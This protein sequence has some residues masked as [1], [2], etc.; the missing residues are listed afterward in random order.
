MLLCPI[1]DDKESPVAQMVEALMKRFEGV[2]ERCRSGRP[3][4][5]GEVEREIQEA[6]NAVGLA[7]MEVVLQSFDPGVAEIE[8]EGERMRR[9][10]N[11]S[12]EYVTRFGMAR[13]GRGLYRGSGRKA[14]T[15]CPLEAGA[16]IIGGL[17]TPGAARLMA[18]M[19]A[20]LTL[21]DTQQLCQELGM[22]VSSSSLGRLLQLLSKAWEARRETHETALREAQMVP[23]EAAV[24]SASV[25]GVLAPMREKAASRQVKREAAGKHA[26]G[27]AGYSEVG[28][29]TASLHDGDGARLSTIY[30]ARMPEPK[31]ATLGEELK[32]EI[33]HLQLLQ[34]DLRRVYL[35]DGAAVNWQIAGSIEAAVRQQCEQEHTSYQKAVEI[36]D[37]FH[38]CEHLKR[39]CDASC[40]EGTPEGKTV[41]ENLRTKLKELDGG[42]DCVINALR[43]RHRKAKRG[44]DRIA[45]ELNYFRK[46]RARMHYARYQRENLPI[47]SGVVEA[48]C[49]TIVTQRMK[50][51]GMAWSPEG[52]QAILTLRTWLRSNRFDLAWQILSDCFKSAPDSLHTYAEPRL[53]MAA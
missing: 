4:D 21:R 38:A 53:K 25:D 36:V 31:K 23:P 22:Q 16:G 52:G 9:V 14:K 46:Q 13:V 29:G 30:Q 3:V 40:G 43:Y 41:F 8:F 11:S 12:A 51:S 44:R 35:A 18:L 50:R 28:C 7:C 20:E 17:W 10:L 49:K 37:Y 19:A 24:V 1:A 15:V 47:G 32:A 27:P 26:S 45:P 42:V 33:L 48:A 5:V 6:I 34:P 2:V 39:A